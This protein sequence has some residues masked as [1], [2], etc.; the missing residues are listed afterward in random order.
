MS[1]LE[2]RNFI[3]IS[4]KI[5]LLFSLGLF[6]RF[7]ADLN[8]F[9]FLAFL[10]ASLEYKNILY[11]FEDFYQSFY[12]NTDLKYFDTNHLTSLSKISFNSNSS[13]DNTG[14]NTRNILKESVECSNRS[15][16]VDSS[17]IDRFRRRVS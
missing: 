12:T 15:L 11:I 2:K 8:S 17:L 13:G 10:F 4:L 3:R 14:N 1:F 7:L 9:E 16:N 5:I 6:I